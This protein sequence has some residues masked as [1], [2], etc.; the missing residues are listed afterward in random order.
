MPEAAPATDL[1]DRKSIRDDALEKEK[2]AQDD[3]SEKLSSL[4]DLVKSQQDHMAHLVKAMTLMAE[5]V[6][7]IEQKP[8]GAR[9]S[10]SGNEPPVSTSGT[11]SSS[12]SFVRTP[13][14]IQVRVQM[15]M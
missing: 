5:R 13:I 9:S 10:Q 12:A 14:R 4:T 8:A 1:P 7:V 2:K 3:L 6:S 15:Q 11:V